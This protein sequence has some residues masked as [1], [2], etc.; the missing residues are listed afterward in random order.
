MTEPGRTPARRSY[1]PKVEALEALRLLDTG[2]LPSALAPALAEVVPAL[3]PGEAP[4]VEPTHDAAGAAWDAALGQSEVGA[5]LGRNAAAAVPL[6][7]ASPAPAPTLDAELEAEAIRS[8]LNQLTRYLGRAW[9]RAGIEPQQFEDCTQEVYETLL[10]RLG[11]DG[12]EHLAAHVG[13]DGVRQVLNKATAD[14]PDFFRAVDMVKKRTQRLRCFQ[15][16]DAHYAE[17]ADLA[18]T[19][20]ASASDWRHELDEAIERALTPREAALI[21]ATLQGMSP[22]EIAAGW[23]VAPKTVSNEKTRAIQK[24]RATLTATLDD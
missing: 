14:G 18:G 7:A 16:L 11:R 20:G 15:P 19:D 10:S 21:R 12:F 5:L 8:G 13:R 6:T 3:H 2:L 24:L 23:G 17:L 9:A 22:Q 4:A 1:R